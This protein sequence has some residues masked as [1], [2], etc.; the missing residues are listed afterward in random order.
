M[1]AYLINI[2]NNFNYRKRLLPIVLK[3]QTRLSNECLH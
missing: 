3:Q 1:L 2:G